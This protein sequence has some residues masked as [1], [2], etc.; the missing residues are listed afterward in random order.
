MHQQCSAQINAAH[1]ED[2]IFQLKAEKE[3]CVDNITRLEDGIS[4]LK[5]LNE[6]CAS[7]VEGLGDDIL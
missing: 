3:Q 2:D 4:Q 7:A 6:Q 1:L 5:F